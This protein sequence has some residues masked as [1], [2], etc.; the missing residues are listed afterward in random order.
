MRNI[1]NISRHDILKIAKWC[2]TN[3][4]T[5]NSKPAPRIVFYT[6]KKYDGWLG[7]YDWDDN[8]IEVNRDGHRSVLD[9]CD[10]M[11]HEWSHY[12]QPY[13]QF[14]KRDEHM[15]YNENP[16]EQEAEHRASIWKRICL[17]EVFK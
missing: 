7:M 3:L 5:K 1:K 16:Y 17:N 14:S 15:D 9:I 2:K 13:R 8:I 10:T 12:L 4:G 11:I 6:K